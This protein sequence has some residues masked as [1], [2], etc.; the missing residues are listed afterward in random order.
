MSRWTHK[1][2]EQSDHELRSQHFLPCPLVS[3]KVWHDPCAPK[4]W[5]EVDLVE[6]AP[7]GVWTWSRCPRVQTSWPKI[8]CKELSWTWK[9]DH[10]QTPRSNVVSLCSG[11]QSD[12]WTERQTDRQAN[13]LNRKEPH[14]KTFLNFLCMGRWETSNPAKFLPFHFV[15]DELII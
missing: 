13:I 8:T 14:R 6:K 5:E 10:N 4:P 11:S 2:E 3:K 15:K 12:W 9:F 1:T 7:F